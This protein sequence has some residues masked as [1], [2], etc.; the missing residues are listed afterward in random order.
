MKTMTDEL[1]LA[2]ARH[3]T[4]RLSNEVAAI[5]GGA[6]SLAAIAA[7]GAA[8]AGALEALAA[9]AAADREAALCARRQDAALGDLLEH[10]IAIQFDA[11]LDGAQRAP[12]AALSR[13]LALATGGRGGQVNPGRPAAVRAGEAAAV[14]T[15][16]TRRSSGAEAL[17]AL[18]GLPALGGRTLGD[19]LSAYVA[20]SEAFAAAQRARSGRHLLDAAAEPRR[21]LL[22]ELDALRTA[23]AAE[24]CVRPE[25][26]ADLALRL[27]APLALSRLRRPQ[28]SRSLDAATTLPL[29]GLAA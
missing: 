22:A 6:A 5:P 11:D 29:P 8:L 9:G 26:P 7:Q 19:R 3:V 13:A 28:A 16:L 14:R 25:V 20:A 4:G 15:F 18:P 23:I 24:A 10:L 12:A 27:Y 2:T 17:S 21:R 1:L